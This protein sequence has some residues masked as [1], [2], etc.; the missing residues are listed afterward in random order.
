VQQ[1]KTT[2]TKEVL[3]RL[4][5]YWRATNYWFVGQIYLLDTPLLK[6]SLTLEHIKTR[7]LGHGNDSG[8]SLNQIIKKEA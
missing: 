2:L 6:K 8:I 4:D 7:L 1:K 5:A 3:P